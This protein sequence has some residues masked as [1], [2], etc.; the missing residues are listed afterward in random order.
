MS[1]T[2]A[3]NRTWAARCLNSPFKGEGIW[4]MKYFP[5]RLWSEQRRQSPFVIFFYDALLQPQ[6]TWPSSSPFTS[7]SRRCLQPMRSGFVCFCAFVSL[8]CF[9]FF[10]FFFLV[11]T[12]SLGDWRV[13][14]F[15]C[16]CCFCNFF[17]GSE[18]KQS[19]ESQHQTKIFRQ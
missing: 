4:H 6:I 8:V 2:E 7:S 18:A 12:R 16:G 5:L 10:F 9:G 11:L 13:L 17:V 1:W 15:F 19:K 3:S 14:F